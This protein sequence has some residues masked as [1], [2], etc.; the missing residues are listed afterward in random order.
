MAAVAMGGTA[1]LA[2]A[3]ARSAVVM[4]LPTITSRVNV[5]IVRRA[6]LMLSSINLR[7]SETLR[8]GRRRVVLPAAL[9]I[10][11]AV[12]LWWKWRLRRRTAETARRLLAIAGSVGLAVPSTVG[13]RHATLTLTLVLLLVLQLLQ[14]GSLLLQLLFCFLP[15]AHR[16]S[17]SGDGRRTLGLKLYCLLVGG[18]D[19]ALGLH[20]LILES[21]AGLDECRGLSRS[22]SATSTALLCLLFSE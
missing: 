13:T 2:V 12:R 9:A 6:L 20:L 21:G 14:L 7:S 22:A 17:C 5:R 19:G 3:M 15:L 11:R 4:L 8:R 16:L 10:V 18:G 1:T